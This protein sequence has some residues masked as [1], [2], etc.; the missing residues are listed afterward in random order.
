MIKNISLFL[1]FISMIFPL[2]AQ[3]DTSLTL[4]KKK[5]IILPSQNKKADYIA[6]KL[7]SII[8]SQASSIGRFEIIDRNIVDNIIKE[9]KFQLSGS[10]LDKDI[11][12]IGELAAA[13]EALI[14]EIIHFGQKG[15][16]VEKKSRE[17]KQEEDHDETLFSWFV[18]TAVKATIEEKKTVDTLRI[19]L[20]LRNNIQTII[21]ANIKFVNI[22][23]G[24]LLKS[25]PISAS[26]T[27]GNKDASLLKVLNILTRQVRWKLKDLYMINSEIIEVE[28]RSVT[29]FS[30]ENLG[31]KKGAIFEISSSDQL[32]TYKGKSLT[33]PGK[34]K[35]LMKIINVGPD[36]SIGK[37][38][39]KWKNINPGDKA[40]ELKKAPKITSL[41]FSLL[42]ET[43][44]ELSGKFIFNTFSDLSPSINGYLGSIKDS[45]NEMNGYLGFGTNLEYRLLSIF[46]TTYSTSLELPVL[47][48]FRNDDE[49]HNVASFLS[50][51]SINFNIAIQISPYRDLVL[52]IK[53]A[54]TQV[55]GPWQW[56]KNTGKLNKEGN[57]ITETEP[58]VWTRTEPK[59]K[60]PGLYFSIGLRKI[61]F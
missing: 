51:P 35:G 11:I 57:N 5:L 26:Y 13:E 59:F 1:V 34:A 37:I 17:D 39:R 23:S 20:Q 18:K 15:I 33:I 29:M 16:P 49:S 27:G 22:E 61:S 21:E 54:F 19:G 25:I 44:Y 38:I 12:T 24:T 36:A 8:S 48:S 3:L 47:F 46:G 40:Y 50:A 56:Q 2:R 52:S 32:K 14:L 9:Q 10:V 42:K 60:L 4:E 53:Y 41:D 43:K 28:K 31:L 6:G 45:R 58:A 30:G 55:H 7:L